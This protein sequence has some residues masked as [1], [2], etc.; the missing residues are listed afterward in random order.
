[1]S[2]SRSVFQTNLSVH[3]VYSI[4]KEV[5]EIYEVICQLKEKLRQVEN[6][7]CKLLK[8][9][10]SL[11]QDIAVK[12]KT[13]Q[14]DSAFCL[15]LRKKMPMD[16]K[17]G[18]VLI[19]PVVVCWSC[20]R[21]PVRRTFTTSVHFDQRCILLFYSCWSERYILILIL[22]CAAQNVYFTL[23]SQLGLSNILCVFQSRRRNCPLNEF[24]YIA[25]LSII[26]FV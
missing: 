16:P 2:R 13:I 24:H 25:L 19:K 8:T 5:H 4:Q 9:R 15:G 18:P 20:T 3:I 11:E 6:A 12:E 7:L 22:N 1:M 14:I 26:V 10:T 23:A 21:S 17:I